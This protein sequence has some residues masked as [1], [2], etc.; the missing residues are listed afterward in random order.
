MRSSDVRLKSR[1]S[2]T[3][4]YNLSRLAHDWGLEKDKNKREIFPARATH[5]Q[6]DHDG[7]FT[8]C[9][10]TSSFPWKVTIYDRQRRFTAPLSRVP[11]SLLDTYKY[12]ASCITMGGQAGKHYSQ[13]L[14]SFQFHIAYLS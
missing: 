11:W 2:P 14:S 12:L 4:S 3:I 1:W 5:L 9:A 13:L 8:P 7:K 10:R 6:P